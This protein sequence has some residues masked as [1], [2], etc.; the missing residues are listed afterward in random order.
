MG[1]L[2]IILM[3]LSL[4]HILPLQAVYLN[5]QVLGF[6]ASTWLISD[7]IGGEF[8][9][10]ILGKFQE[11]WIHSG[12]QQGPSVSGPSESLDLEFWY[13]TLTVFFYGK[14]KM[15]VILF[16]VSLTVLSFWKL[17]CSSVLYLSCPFLCISL[18]I[19]SRKTN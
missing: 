3:Y 8:S 17:F 16:L 2:S 19:P 15:I 7:S 6:T 18:P 4:I 12:F 1:S 14:Y 13:F 9:G 5:H 10:Q 11:H